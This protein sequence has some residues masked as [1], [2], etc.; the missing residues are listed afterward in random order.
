MKK[1]KTTTIISLIA[2]A[3]VVIVTGLA[4]GFTTRYDE[5]DQE[6]FNAAVSADTMVLQ[7]GVVSIDKLQNQVVAL[8][9]NSVVQ[10]DVILENASETQSVPD[11]EDYFPLER[12]NQLTESHQ[13]VMQNLSDEEVTVGGGK[14]NTNLVNSQ[15]ISPT[16]KIIVMTGESWLETIYH[17]DGTYVVNLIFT[18]D[19]ISYRMVNEEGSW[20]VAET[21]SHQMEFAPDDYQ[22]DK[23]TFDTFQEAVEFA[24]QLDVEA[25]N[26][27]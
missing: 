12:A 17:R 20:K 8:S 11:Y 18:R 13:A 19:T 27:F 25:E 22:G 16:E 14:L 10:E 5:V 26:P 23:G 15:D 9:E 6:A 7:T 4:T 21:L 2:L 1:K 24:A 3:A